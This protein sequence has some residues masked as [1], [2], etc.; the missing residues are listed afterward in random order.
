MKIIGDMDKRTK[1]ILKDSAQHAEAI[2]LIKIVYITPE[3]IIKSAKAKEFL[4]Y[5]T[6][7]NVLRRIIVDECH[8]IVN[9]GQTFR[10]ACVE[11]M[12]V[13]MIDLQIQQST[14]AMSN[15]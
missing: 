7:R 8:Y 11:V 6:E 1:E 3:K 5:L 4:Q 10:S 2:S 14:I 12:S 13:L 15:L 9:W